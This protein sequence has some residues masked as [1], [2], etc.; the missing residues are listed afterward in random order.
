MNILNF[1]ENMLYN[2][3]KNK[4]PDEIYAG[5]IVKIYQTELEELKKNNTNNEEDLLN[6]KRLEISIEALNNYY[7]ID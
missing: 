3:N 7:D 6:R 4:Q 1:I 5:F 2:K